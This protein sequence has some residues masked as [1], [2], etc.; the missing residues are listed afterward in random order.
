MEHWSYDTGGCLSL[1]LSTNH[2]DLARASY[3]SLARSNYCVRAR[4]PITICSKAYLAL[5]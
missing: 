5:I 4:D 2:A 1:G 3:L